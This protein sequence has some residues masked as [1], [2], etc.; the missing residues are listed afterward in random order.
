MHSISTRRNAVAPA[1]RSIWQSPSHRRNCWLSLRGPPAQR[2]GRQ[3]IRAAGD[4]SATAWHSLPPAWERMRFSGCSTAWRCGSRRCFGGSRIRPVRLAGRTCRAG[5]RTG[6]QRGNPWL[7]PACRGR[8]AASRRAAASG[9][10]RSRPRCGTRRRRR[11]AE[12]RRRRS[13]EALLSVL[14]APQRRQMFSTRR[15]S[16][17]SAGSP[18]SGGG[19]CRRFQ[20]TERLGGHC[21]AVGCRVD[22]AEPRRRA[23]DRSA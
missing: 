18:N 2:R 21:A 4:R 20:T 9:V 22:P 7:Q 11:C 6:R 12:L 10:R 13:L 14:N 8:C 16:D 17:S 5:A 23:A 15:P 1:C 3:P 19:S